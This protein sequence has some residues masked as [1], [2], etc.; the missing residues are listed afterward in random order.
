M[1]IGK[2]M[3]AVRKFDRQLLAC[4]TY[5]WPVQLASQVDNLEFFEQCTQMIQH[6]M[7][8]RTCTLAAAKYQEDRQLAR[9][10]K[11]RMRSLTVPEGEVRAQWIA[12]LK[13]RFVKVLLR[14]VSSHS[15]HIR[16]PSQ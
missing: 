16:K 3:I 4:S 1:Q 15:D 10:T 2:S 6:G 11:V 14:L 5:I 7:I 12:S 13:D 8:D 9:N